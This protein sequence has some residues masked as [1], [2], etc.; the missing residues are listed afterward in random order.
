MS[1][2]LTLR[3]RARHGDGTGPFSA[4]MLF[5]ALWAIDYL[6]VLASPD[7]ASKLLWYHFEWSAYAWYP[8]PGLPS[9]WT[10]RDTA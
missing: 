8:R 1:L 3:S 6:F 10:S 2:T 5:A 9:Q 4:M 7:L